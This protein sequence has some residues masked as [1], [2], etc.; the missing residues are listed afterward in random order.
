MSDQSTMQT[1]PNIQP[2]ATHHSSLATETRHMFL[3]LGP[4]HPA[5]HGIIQIIVELDGERVVSSDVEIGYLH[6]RSRKNPSGHPTT[7]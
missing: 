2:L 7:T 6:R 5:M 1:N 3:N 4:S